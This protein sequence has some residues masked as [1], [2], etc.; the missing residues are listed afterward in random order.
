[1]SWNVLGEVAS[2]S[3]EVGLFRFFCV[4]AGVEEV[5]IVP[6][7]DMS[8]MFCVWIFKAERLSTGLYLGWRIVCADFIPEEVGGVVGA[9]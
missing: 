4:S 5:Y 9:G 3:Q 8:G 2:E 6:Q 1:M 7:E